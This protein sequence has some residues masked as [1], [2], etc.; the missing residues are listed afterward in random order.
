MS[1]G[2]QY[3]K[4]SLESLFGVILHAHSPSVICTLHFLPKQYR[5][6]VGQSDLFDKE[7]H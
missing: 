6:A 3:S 7:Q 1:R 5:N 4:R 2:T